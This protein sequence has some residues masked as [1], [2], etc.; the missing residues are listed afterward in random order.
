MT[1]LKSEKH[2][3]KIRPKKRDGKVTAVVLGLDQYRR[4]KALN[5]NISMVVRELVDEYLKQN[6]PD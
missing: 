5:L 2:T 6:F 1:I 3:K 4:M